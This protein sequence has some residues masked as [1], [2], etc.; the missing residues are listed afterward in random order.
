MPLTVITASLVVGSRY[1]VDPEVAVTAPDGAAL[2]V[3]VRDLDRACCRG[4]GHSALDMNG[5]CGAVCHGLCSSNR[6]CMSRFAVGRNVQVAAGQTDQAETGGVD[7]VGNLVLDGVEI[8]D[9]IIRRCHRAERVGGGVDRLR[10]FVVDVGGSGES[11]AGNRRDRARGA[12]Q[13]QVGSVVAVPV[14]S[15]PVTLPEPP[16]SNLM[17]VVLP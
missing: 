2:N 16:F 6:P 10:R 9:G 4:E 13:Q 7:S 17:P 1:V 14:K 12:G 11:I 3:P 5:I 8:G 15:L